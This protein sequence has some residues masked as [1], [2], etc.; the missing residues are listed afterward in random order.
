[1]LPEYDKA[2]S[3]GGFS[4][5]IQAQDANAHDL[6]LNLAP[7]RDRHQALLWKSSVLFLPQLWNQLYQ[8][9]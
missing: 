5:F 3:N 6:P 4:I 1:M 9:P 7:V 8:L 2:T